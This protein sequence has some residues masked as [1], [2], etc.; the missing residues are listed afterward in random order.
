[1]LRACVQPR[2]SR[3]SND[4]VTHPL[5]EDG[6]HLAVSDAVEEVRMSI[7]IIH[8]PRT[9]IVAFH[10]ACSARCVDLPGENDEGSQVSGAPM[11]VRHCSWT[12]VGS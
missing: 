7:S 12:P 11:R 8:P 4:S 2:V 6:S 5:I 3:S 10:S 9:F 1:V